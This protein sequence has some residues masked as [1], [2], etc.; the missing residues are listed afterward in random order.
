M[1][2]VMVMVLV[3]IGVPFSAWIVGLSEVVEDAQVLLL[4]FYLSILAQGQM[5][6]PSKK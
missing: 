5:I 4:V 6:S 3:L 2:L 1:V